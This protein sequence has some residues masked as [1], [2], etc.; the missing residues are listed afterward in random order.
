MFARKVNCD[1]EPVGA[2]LARDKGAANIRQ[3]ASSLIASKLCFYMKS[4][5]SA[6]EQA[7]L[8]HEKSG[9]SSRANVA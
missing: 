6:R 1:A 7:L 3:I 4:L 9:I 8:L 5:V 2:E